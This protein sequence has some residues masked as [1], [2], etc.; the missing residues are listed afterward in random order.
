MLLSIRFDQ[1]YFAREVEPPVS[2]WKVAEGD[3]SWVRLITDHLRSK[4]TT[5]YAFILRFWYDFCNSNLLEY[6]ISKAM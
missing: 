6:G 1:I 3:E 2:Y 5:L 4:A